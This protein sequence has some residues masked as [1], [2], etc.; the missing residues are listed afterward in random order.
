M[1]AGFTDCR[2][3]V[4]PFSGIVR[5]AKKK[6]PMPVLTLGAEAGIGE[7]IVMVMRAPAVD[8]RRAVLRDCGHYVPEERPERLVERC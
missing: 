2:T 3:L 8:D 4:R 7:S 1:P 6:L 5:Y